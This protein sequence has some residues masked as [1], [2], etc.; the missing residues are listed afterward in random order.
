MSE[1]VSGMIFQ[2]HGWVPVSVFHGQKRRFRASAE[3]YW[4]DCYVE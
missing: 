4:E 1:A 3:G 2:D